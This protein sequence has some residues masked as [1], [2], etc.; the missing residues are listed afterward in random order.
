MSAKNNFHAVESVIPLPWAITPEGMADLSAILPD[1]EP[2]NVQAD[3]WEEY[4]TRKA[5]EQNGL[6]I[7][8]GVAIQ[9]VRGCIVAG[10]GPEW[11][12]FCGCFNLDRI[13]A[14]VER[15]QGDS[16]IRA[17][18]LAVDSPG[19]YTKGMGEAVAAL[20]GLRAARADLATA[21]W[22]DEACSAG[23][24]LAAA[25]EKIHAAPG[26]DI[27]S[28]GVYCATY[29]YSKMAEQSGILVRLFADGKY[30]GMGTPGVEWKPE[31]YEWVQARVDECSAA[32][33]GFIRGAR[34]GITEETM[35]GQ[36]FSGPEY[37]AGLVDS[38]EHRT[39]EALFGRMKDEG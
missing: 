37:P 21:A 22:C 11:E 27:G 7:E 18:I 36:Y 29:D 31:W 26:A 38:T 9:P 23:Y 24:W 14:A 28:I 20:S 1:Y 15:V 10:A 17:F 32:F 35:Q 13:T 8:G 19:G 25:M 30:K 5:D 3:A 4:V 16:S 6:R 34:K 39:L 2:A 33:K 12:Y